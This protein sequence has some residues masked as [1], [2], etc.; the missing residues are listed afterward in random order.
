M[1]AA[2]EAEMRTAAALVD[3]VERIKFVSDFFAA[4]DGGL[5]Q[6]AEVRL[7]AVAALRA[8]GLTYDRI[9]EVTGL[10]KPRVA[11]LAREAAARP[12][13]GTAEE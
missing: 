8:Q 3:P 13:P 1:R 2:I 9:A 5:E 4:I 10:S 6:V 11:Q 12:G 7:D